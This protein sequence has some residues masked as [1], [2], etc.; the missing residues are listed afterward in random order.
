MNMEPSWHRAVIEVLLRGSDR[1]LYRHSPVFRQSVDMLVAML[2]DM[3]GGLAEGAKIDEQR[4]REHERIMRV[5]PPQPFFIPDP[6]E[7]S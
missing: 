2:P 6:K 4:H 1:D 7:Q 3:V 5:T